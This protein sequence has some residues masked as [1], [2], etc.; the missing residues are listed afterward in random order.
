MGYE[1]GVDLG[2]TAVAAAD[3]KPEF[4]Y[5]TVKRCADGLQLRSFELKKDFSG[6]E[7]GRTMV[8]LKSFSSI[9]TSFTPDLETNLI[10]S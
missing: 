2:G 6:F 9:E 3:Y 10:S 4:H 1:L 8:I 5:L 7:E